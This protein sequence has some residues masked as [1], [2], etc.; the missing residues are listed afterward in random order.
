MYGINTSSA[1]L[2]SYI[3]SGLELAE[4]YIYCAASRN[5]VSCIAVQYV[6]IPNDTRWGPL[7][8]G[9]AL[10]IDRQRRMKS[11]SGEVS[12]Q[13]GHLDDMFPAERPL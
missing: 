12:P 3:T 1:A 8:F 9:I 6:G 11:A 2:L 5:K 13:A 4:L 7:H 10:L